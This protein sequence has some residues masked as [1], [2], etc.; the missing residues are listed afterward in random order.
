MV[1]VADR[2]SH[3]KGNGHICRVSAWPRESL[4]FNSFKD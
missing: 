1:Y 2:Y 3:V 4:E